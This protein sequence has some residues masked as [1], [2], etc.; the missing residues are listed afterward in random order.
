MPSEEDLTPV[1]PGPP[2]I[3]TLRPHQQSG[4]AF[5][6]DREGED[7]LAAQPLWK[8]VCLGI[9]AYGPMSSPA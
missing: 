9:L 6:L 7:C 2:I 4:L 5:M 8:N 3:A 1:S